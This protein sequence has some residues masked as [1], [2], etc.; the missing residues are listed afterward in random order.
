M[1]LRERLSASAAEIKARSQRLVELNFELLTSELK[2]KAQPYG[3]AIGVFVAA[4]VLALYV[5]GFALATIAVALYIVLPLWLSLLIVTVALLLVV[6]I[7]VL[8]GRANLRKV[9]TARPERTIAEAKTTVDTLKS[10]L[11]QTVNDLA[12]RR[13]GGAGAVVAP[14]FTP[15]PL[16]S[17]PPRPDEG[18]TEPPQTPPTTP[19]SD[20]EVS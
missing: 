2:R 17:A 3:T 4:G 19:T 7:L 18:P 11:Q 10:E 6:L 9:K 14:P 12:P 15:P 5:L 13:N 8:V 16:A 20:Q 1:G